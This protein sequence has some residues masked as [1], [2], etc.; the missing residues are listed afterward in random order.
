VSLDV[1]PVSGRRDLKEFIDLPYRLHSN[2]PQWV[3]PLRLERWM[4]LTKRLNPFFTHGDAQLFLARR[5]GRVVGRISAQYNDSFNAQHD[6]RWGMFG[7]LEF[8]DDA[9]ILSAML[10]AAGEWLT[11]RGYDRMVGPMDFAMNDES[12]VM[13]EG[14]DRMPM[15]RQPWHPPYYFE[16]CEEAGLAKAQDLFMYE[17][18]IADRSKML[19]IIFK[20]AAQVEPRHGIRIRRMSR[21]SLRR[22]MD[23]F[24]EVYNSAWAENWDFVPYSKADLDTY[25][26][27]MQL[28]FD[29]NW[30]MVAET[31]EGDTAAVAITIPDINQV[32]KKMKGRLVP[33]GWWHFLRRKKIMDRVRVGFLGVKPEYQH[34]GVAAALY[35]EHFDTAT[36]RPQTWGEMGWILESNRN[37]NKAMEAMGGRIVRRYR[38]YERELGPSAST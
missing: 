38:M 19:P 36:K 11:A 3:P 24:A 17:L 37:M 26:L 6:N 27:D 14:F 18:D 32:L 10:D 8:E 2:S 35:V 30:F 28:V 15:I 4:F 20:L 12:G 5:D 33:F 31:P 16:R 29:P 1:R 7:F 23:R 21:R 22:D 34:T 13:F 25:A 9:E